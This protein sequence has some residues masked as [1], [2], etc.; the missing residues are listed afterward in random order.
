MRNADQLLEIDYKGI[1]YISIGHC[2]ERVDHHWPCEGDFNSF[3][4]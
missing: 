2:C 3:L 1:K 4:N